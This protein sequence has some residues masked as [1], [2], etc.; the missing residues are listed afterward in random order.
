MGRSCLP[1][2]R[3][4]FFGEGMLDGGT[5]EA[6]FSHRVD[7]GGGSEIPRADIAHSFLC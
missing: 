5:G 2:V 7:V 1:N 4:M 6:G 3:F